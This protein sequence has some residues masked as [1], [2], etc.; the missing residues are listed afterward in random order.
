MGGGEYP[1]LDGSGGEANQRFVKTT[2][3]P[4]ATKKSSGELAGL[5][6]L[7]PL[8]ALLCVGVGVGIAPVTDDDGRIE[9]AIV[10]KIVIV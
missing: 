7:L 8:G 5:L 9:V 1:R 3:K 10:D 6:E 2:P 4:S